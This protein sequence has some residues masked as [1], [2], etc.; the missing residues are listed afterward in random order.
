FPRAPRPGNSPNGVARPSPAPTALAWVSGE[1][2]EEL[3]ELRL[4]VGLGDR[5][6][7]LVAALR[8]EAAERHAGE[9]PLLGQRVDEPAGVAPA[10]ADADLVEEGRVAHERV[11]LEGADPLGEVARLGEALFGGLHEA[12][13]AQHAHLD[14]EG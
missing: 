10:D 3:V 13:F 1:G 2:G 14:G 5:D 7:E 6:E 9:D 12:A 11:A 8:I 4:E